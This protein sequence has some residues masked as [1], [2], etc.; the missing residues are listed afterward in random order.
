MTEIWYQYAPAAA[1]QNKNTFFSLIKSNK[2]KTNIIFKFSP[3]CFEIYFVCK[4]A[5]NHQSDHNS[6][7][8]FKLS[9]F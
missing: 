7:V 2:Q 1:L 9:A 8:G 5:S 3:K 6:I 4:T